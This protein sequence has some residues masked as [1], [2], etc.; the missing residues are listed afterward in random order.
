M[1][2]VRFIIS[3]WLLSWI[4]SIRNAGYHAVPWDRVCALVRRQPFGKYYNL[5]PRMRDSGGELLPDVS[6]YVSQNDIYMNIWN[7]LWSSGETCSLADENCEARHNETES[8]TE[9]AQMPG[10]QIPSRT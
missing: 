4:V 7:M 10:N 3:S 1:V 6:S 5:Q 8:N 9:M 2:D